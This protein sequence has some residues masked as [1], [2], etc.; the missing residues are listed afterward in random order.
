[1][2]AA[3]NLAIGKLRLS[4]RD[5]RQQIEGLIGIIGQ[6]DVFMLDV[7]S[8]EIVKRILATK[9]KTTQAHQ[10]GVHESPLKNYDEEERKAVSAS[11]AVTYRKRHNRMTAALERIFTRFHPITETTPAGR[12]DCNHVLNASSPSIYLSRFSIILILSLL[13]RYKF[14]VVIRKIR[15]KTGFPCLVILRAESLPTNGFTF[16]APLRNVD[17][18]NRL[19]ETLPMQRARYLGRRFLL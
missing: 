19:P 15:W 9:Q 14:E 10:G 18:K 7:L 8:D 13:S 6:K 2:I 11:K 4:H 17:L 5:L 16:P 3:G 12:C 1:M